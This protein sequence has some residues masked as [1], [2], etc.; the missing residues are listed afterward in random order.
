MSGTS[1]QSHDEVVE[2]IANNSMSDVKTLY[3]SNY[4][5][6]KPIVNQDSVEPSTILPI[7]YAC[8]QGS[9]DVLKFFLEIGLEANIP[10]TDGKLP[11]HFTC[12]SNERVDDKKE[13]CVQALQILIQANCD[14]NVVDNMGRTPLFLACE[15]D[16]VEAVKLLLVESR[17]DV[18]IKTV[19]GDSPMKVA[20][21]NAKYWSYWHG[22]ELNSAGRKIN[23]FDF[24]PV[25][26]T[27]MLLQANADV[28]EATLL[29]TA[30]QL[31]D[32]KLVEE[33]LNLG[34]D[35][36]MLD[37]NM[38]TPLGI[39]CSNTH[40][41]SQLVKLLL[42]RGADVNKGG[43]WKKQKPLIFAYVHN[44]VEKIKLLLSYGA[45]LTAEEMTEL[46]SLTLSKSI[47]ENPEV[48]G[49]NSKELLSW[50]LLMA[51]GFSPVIQGTELHCKVHKLS[52]CSSYD[53]I[54]P[55]IRSLLYPVHSLKQLCRVSIRGNVHVPID[56]N[57]DKLPVPHSIQ[58]FLKVNEIF[59]NEQL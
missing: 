38:C 58:D 18:N 34:M 23:S 49:P 35:I 14:V 12:D 31:G 53:K 4:D 7:S 1:L 37:D 48:I 13:E 32:T 26:I 30:V 45:K 25:Q 56:K 55:W 9:V 42:D 20:C 2:A 15:A 8:A 52:I 51:Q 10:G 22:K 44:S 19:V 59:I 40:V 17:C 24:P 6:N 29:P 47:L 5:F 16:D 27:K 39:A 33:L 28:S 54:E 36:N 43:G 41:R 11:I 57:I 46:V 21:R 3:A 50:R